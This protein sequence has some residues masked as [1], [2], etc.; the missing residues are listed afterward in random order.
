M[1]FET[2][3]RFALI[4][5]VLM[6]V[7]YVYHCLYW[8]GLAVDDSFITFRYAK[9]FCNG[10]GLVYNSGERVEGYSNFSWLLM[11]AGGVKLGFE[12]IIVAKFLG[13]LSGLGCIICSFWLCSGFCSVLFSLLPPL[14]LCTNSFFCYWS[15]SGMETTFFS[16]ILIL[17]A[18]LYLREGESHPFSAYTLGLLCMSR[19]DGFGYA[20]IFLAVDIF[21]GIRDKR[22]LGRAGKKFYS[23]FLFIAFAYLGFKLVYYGSLLPNTYYAKLAFPFQTRNYRYFLYFFF[24]HRL[25]L[26]LLL[27]FS[28]SACFKFLKFK[29]LLPVFLLLFNWF[30]IIYSPDWMPN[31]RYYMHTI[32]ILFTVISIGIWEI[33]NRVNKNYAVIALLLLA[34]HIAINVNIKTESDYNRRHPYEEKSSGWLM[35]VPENI[36]AGIWPS[37]INMTMFMIENTNNS[38]TV[39]MRDIGFPNFILG[40][41]VYDQAMLVSKEAGTKFAVIKKQKNI[42]SYI[43]GNMRKNLK[44]YSP[45]FFVYPLFFRHTLEKRHIRQMYKEHIESDMVLI[46]A[47]KRFEYYRK[48]SLSWYIPQK[49]LIRKY[50]DIVR[51][52]P[53]YPAFRYRLDTLRGLS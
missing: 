8:Y 34:H 1:S 4:S 12:P 9:N 48:K 11:I 22:R 40:T 53:S 26:L 33:I 37:L 38:M 21:L 27:I 28:L 2:K 25:P 43:Y 5:L 3:N 13:I 31:Y 14:L 49:E 17:S 36:K 18:V 32:P 29:N 35:D 42:L 15:S 47:G 46:K 45:D 51:E 23:I 41:R 20:A 7:F 24:N 44:F 19:P 10:L 16:F 39:G 50:E 52:H 30:F 6:A